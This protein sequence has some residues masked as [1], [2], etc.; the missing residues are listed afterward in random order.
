MARRRPTEDDD[1]SLFPF[2]S[3]IAALIGVLTLM[4]AAVTLGQMNE[5]DVKE[6]VENAIELDKLQAELQATNDLAEK[7]R[8][9]LNAE[10]S[11]L[12]KRAGARQAELV[13]SRAEL[14]SLLKRLAE[15]RE[16]AEEIKKVKIVIPEIPEGSRETSSDLQEQLAAIKEQLALLQKDLKS[17]KE[18]P[19]EAEV[20]IVP[21]GTGISFVPKFVE[22]RGGAVVLHTESPPLTIRTA[23]IVANAR[24]VALLEQVANSQNQ[25]IVLL[26]R[27]DSLGTYRAVKKLCDQHE[28]RHG[29][30]PVV[31]NGRLDFS[32]FRKS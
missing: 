28:V 30:L 13:K 18:P 23:E 24:F 29:K 15:A 25:S 2:L 4:I 21:G 1:V 6:T 17:R 5:D 12:L 27:N 22:C 11:Q 20:S 14:E 10:Q 31:G 3:I 19:K 7:L 16:K 8:L 26:L 9:S 32:H